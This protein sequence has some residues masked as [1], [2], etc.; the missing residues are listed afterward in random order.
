MPRS[1]DPLARTHLTAREKRAVAAFV[2]ELRAALG[3]ELVRVTL[4]GS[5]VRG[6]GG[7]ASDVDL[8]VLLRTKDRRAEQAVFK[9]VVDVE[10]VTD[11]PLAPIVYSRRRYDRNKRLGSPFIAAVEREGVAL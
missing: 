5:K 4:F 9:L 6:D 1:R 3:D 8:L 7:R 10:L 11:T 2:R